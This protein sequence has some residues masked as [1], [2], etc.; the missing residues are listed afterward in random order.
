MRILSALGGML[1]VLGGALLV[2][3][4]LVLAF[5]A[6]TAHTA[7]D[8]YSTVFYGVLGLV[9]IIIGALTLFRR[10]RKKA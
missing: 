7:K 9:N 5:E 4:G 2:V 8:V 10:R 6:L 1:L 3:G